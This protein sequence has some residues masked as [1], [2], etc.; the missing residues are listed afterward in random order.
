MRVELLLVSADTG[1]RVCCNTPCDGVCSTCDASGTCVAPNDDSNCGTILCAASTTCR[2]YPATMTSDRCKSVGVCKS[3]TD[4]YY[5]NAPGRTPCAGTA[6]NQRLCDGAGQCVQPTMQC[7][8]VTCS[9]GPGYCC[10]GWLAGASTATLGCDT[11]CGMDTGMVFGC[12]NE[13]DCPTGTVCC[14]EGM[15]LGVSS[16]T[17]PS[18]CV[19]GPGFPVQ[20]LCDPDATTTVCPSGR[21][22]QPFGASGSVSFY[23]CG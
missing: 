15:S 13:T 7:G 18:D 12:L 6:P 3:S 1:G 14:R 2:S 23:F 8:S 21:T 9:L 10:D 4:C 17:A 22:C 16:C 20:I 5:T 19:L 11:V